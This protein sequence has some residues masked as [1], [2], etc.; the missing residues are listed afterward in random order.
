[1]SNEG[2]VCS[3]EPEGKEGTNRPTVGAD[4]GEVGNPTTRK[5]SWEP[6]RR[7]TETLAHPLPN[8]PGGAEEQEP[9]PAAVDAGKAKHRRR[10]VKKNAHG[11]SA[12]GGRRE[13]EAE[14]NSNRRRRKR[15]SSE[16]NANDCEN[17]A[18]LT[19]NE[20]GPTAARTL[21]AGRSVCKPAATAGVKPRKTKIRTGAA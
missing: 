15:H 11:V 13:H 21:G 14:V 7:S 9:T 18:P 2:G 20:T 3:A 1:L 10:K 16:E 6:G 8:E 12:A 19:K 17:L 5:K 4:E